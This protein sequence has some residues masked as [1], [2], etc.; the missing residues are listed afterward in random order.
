MTSLCAKE[1][2]RARVILADDHPDV[3][4]SLLALVEPEFDV[5]A[6]VGDG[7][8]LVAAAASLTPDVIVTDISM[9]GLNGISAA[10]Q[11]LRSNPA[12]RVVFVTVHNH[13]VLVEKGLAIG[14]LG[15]VLKLTAGDDL[16]PAIRDAL[17]GKRHLS[18]TVNIGS[19]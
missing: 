6:T 8:A 10:D 14:A 9:P 5:V 17:Q 16:V 4:E 18:P 12:T 11:I 15:Y 13:P 1:K 2:I 7:K 19:T 3:V